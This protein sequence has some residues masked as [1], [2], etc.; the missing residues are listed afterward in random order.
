MTTNWTK[1]PE[2]LTLNSNQVDVWRV[3]ILN[4]P[5]DSVRWV[6]P[7]LAAEEDRR[8]TRFYFNMDR[9]RFILS[10]SA[11]RDILA[12][13]LNLPPENIQFE[14][15]EYGKPA[16]ASEAELDFNLSH[17]GDFAL[18]AI[19]SGHKVGVDVE[20]HRHDMEHEKI[21]QHFFSEM[22]KSELQKLPND[23]KMIGFFNCW[24]RKEAYIKA[25]GLGLL[26][27]LD[28]FDVSL[29]PNEPTILRATRPDPREASRWSL[30]SLDVYSNHTGAIAVEGK[31]MEFRFWDWDWD[32]T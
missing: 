18:I 25:H 28:S 20:K 16:I 10:H 11:L 22:E 21:G 30:L 6:E 29:A 12:R 32:P 9:H 27:P 8:A 5:P 2:N 4:F 14:I 19:A 26:L 13:Y 3:S 23:Q 7:I 31:E 15:G 17:S 24:T 1:P